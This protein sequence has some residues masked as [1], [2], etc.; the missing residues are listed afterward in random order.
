MKGLIG[1]S[2]CIWLALSMVALFAK[3]L[4]PA[5]FGPSGEVGKSRYSH[6]GGTKC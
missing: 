4:C 3:G 2:R 5:K 1:E 6:Q